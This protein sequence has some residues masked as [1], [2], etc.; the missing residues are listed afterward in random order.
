MVLHSVRDALSH[1]DIDVSDS[2][3]LLIL[4]TTKGNIELLDGKEPVGDGVFPGTP[5]PGLLRHLA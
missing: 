4:S 2:R 3:V 5:L 1:T